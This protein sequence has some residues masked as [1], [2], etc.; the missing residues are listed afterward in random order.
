MSCDWLPGASRA[1]N[2][3]VSLTLTGSLEEHEAD[4]Q[5]E[6]VP[7]NARRGSQTDLVGV[8]NPVQAF[9]LDLLQGQA[10]VRMD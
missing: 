8:E 9:H 2:D 5:P 3:A 1:H 6:G 4:D 7:Q 10:S